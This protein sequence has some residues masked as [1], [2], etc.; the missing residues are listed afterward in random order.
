MKSPKFLSNLSP[1]ARNLFE[2]FPWFEWQQRIERPQEAPRAAGLDFQ[3][4]LISVIKTFNK[5]FG[6]VQE[7]LLQKGFLVAE[8]KSGR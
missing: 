1:T 2:S 7:P 3:K 4:L 5:N 8:G 6:E